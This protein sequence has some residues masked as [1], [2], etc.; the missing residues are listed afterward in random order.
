MQQVKAGRAASLVCVSLA[1]GGLIVLFLSGSAEDS[2]VDNL[3]TTTPDSPL[4]APAPSTQETPL[5]VEVEA[6]EAPSSPL[7]L[8]DECPETLDAGVLTNEKCLDATE[9]HF[10]DSPAYVIWDVGLMPREGRFTYRDMFASSEQDLQLVIDALSRP[11]CRLLE[12]PVRRDLRESCYADAFSRHVALMEMCFSSEHID[13]YFEPYTGLDSS[14]Y[15]NNLA[16]LEHYR[17]VEPMAFPRHKRQN[18]KEWYYVW[19]N[20]FREDILR[21]AWLQS[22][23]KCPTS[24]LREKG[25][26]IEIAAFL[27][28][29]LLPWGQIWRLGDIAARL[30]DERSLVVPYYDLPSG[31][32]L[33][34][35]PLA[36][37]RQSREVH[38]SWMPL[39]HK[40]IRLS[41]Y[42]RSRSEAVARAAKGIV[43]LRKSGYEADVEDLVER[44]CKEKREIKDCATSING[45]EELL[46]PTDMESLRAL[47][48]IED[49]ALKLGLYQRF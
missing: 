18:K 23:G 36:I 12:G 6:N 7:F 21:S 11:E 42:D 48:E 27:D 2:V 32:H 40:A 45:A 37:R 28:G 4:E 17:E 43:A 24:N 26:D 41:R 13:D 29:D 8:G 47:D 19:R 15:T 34:A 33:S 3:S 20:H 25:L 44:I 14:F 16:T 1:A 9:R 46:D 49:A 10:M 5:K 35:E 22:R 38:F 31:R 30:G 39:L